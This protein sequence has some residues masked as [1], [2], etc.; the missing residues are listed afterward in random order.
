MQGKK[1]DS[2]EDIRYMKGVGPKK[3]EL[4]KRLGINTIEDLL[5][6][7]PRRYEDRSNFTLIKDLKPG[8]Y[9]AIKGK[10]LT[11]GGRMTKRGLNVFRIALGDRTGVIY[12]LWFNQPFLKKFFK[13]DQEIVVYGKVE[14]YDKLQINHPE[15]EI[16]TDKRFYQYRKNHPDIFPYR[17][18]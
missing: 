15:Y 17:G 3:A 7:L 11:L 10:V 12:C 8:E 18:C 6:Y 2:K 5:Y 13:T 4:L 1:I 14:R 16:V 9:Q